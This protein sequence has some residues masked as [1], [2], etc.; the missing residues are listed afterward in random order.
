MAWRCRHRTSTRSSPGRTVP[1]LFVDTVAARPDAVALRWRPAGSETATASLDLGGVR[2]P[3]LPG[4]G[5]ARRRSGCS[6]GQRVVLMMRNRP[7]FYP[8]DVGV[9]LAGATPISIYNSSS[10]EQIEYLA[11]HSEADGG[12]RRRRRDAG[13]VPQGPLRAARPAEPRPDRRPGRAGP[14]R[15]RAL[16]RPARRRTR[17][18]RRGGRPGPA[19]GP[20]HP[21]LHLGH[22]RAAQGRD[23]LPLQPVLGAG[24]HDPG[25][26]RAAHRL[27]A[28][29]VPPHG[30]HRRAV[31]HALPPHRRGHRRHHLPRADR[32]GVLPAGG[33]ARA[34]PRRAPGVGEDLRRDHGRRVG[35]PREEGRVRAGARGRRQ[36]GRRPGHRPAAPAGA[37][38][39]LGAGR[40]RRLRQRPG[41]GRPRPDAHRL[42]RRGPD[43]PAGARLL[44]GHRRAAVA[45]STAC[46]RP[47]GRRPGP[48]ASPAR[49]RRRG[50]S[51]ARR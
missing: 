9:L 41:H 6:P 44:P 5:R 28:G 29:L 15:R 25:H 26:R 18:P 10:P 4:G 36:G 23:D 27:A 46:R 20:R 31:A 35:R 51:P 30:P 16:R 24:E 1:S 32:A 22:H 37:G 45:R 2:R 7:E 48:G 19:R 40:R 3:G 42:H 8:A 39:R 34:L 12:H 38:R 33:P 50:R 13:A 11:G 17:R 43:P 47:P 49:H 14:G 21:D